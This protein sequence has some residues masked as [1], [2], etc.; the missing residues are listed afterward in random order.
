MINSHLHH[1]NDWHGVATQHGVT[2]ASFSQCAPNEY[3]NDCI[4][5]KTR[6][7][8]EK[9]TAND[10]WNPTLEEK[11]ERVRVYA[12]QIYIMKLQIMTFSHFSYPRRWREEEK[13]LWFIVCY[14][15][16]N[17]R[18]NKFVPHF[19]LSQWLLCDVSTPL[20]TCNCNVHA[21]RKQFSWLSMRTLIRSTELFSSSYSRFAA[22]GIAK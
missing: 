10:W 22:N 3:K 17:R 2:H 13:N 19:Y 16:Q 4:Q 11:G 1:L 12:L 14:V 8:E 5:E 6:E 9:I 15:T 21:L 20:H 18:L 7:R